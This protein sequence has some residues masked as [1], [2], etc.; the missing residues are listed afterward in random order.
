MNMEDILDDRDKAHEAKFKLDEELRFKA[1]SRRNK[2]FGRWAAELMALPDP[3]GYARDMVMAGMGAD[4]DRAVTSKVLADLKERGVAAAPDEIGTTLADF[5]A[6][7]LKQL[8]QEFPKALGGD[9][10]RVG[11]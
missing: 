2:L 8:R 5:H 3:D 10:Q 7:A 9:H 11:D 4:G 6:Q 1:R